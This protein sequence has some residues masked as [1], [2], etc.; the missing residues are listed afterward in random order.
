MRLCCW[1]LL[2]P[3]FL[4]HI[5]FFPLSQ[6]CFPPSYFLPC[7]SR[8]FI[9]D[10]FALCEAAS[11]ENV[12]L[13]HCGGSVCVCVCVCDPHQS[14]LTQWALCACT[15]FITPLLVTSLLSFY[16][17]AL[18]CSQCQSCPHSHANTHQTLLVSLGGHIAF[19]GIFHLWLNV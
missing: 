5:F 17:I 7:F 13:R 19:L 16:I 18:L 10:H 2:L 12:P 14:T 8:L 6:S 1:L 3:F 4:F 9:W 11:D 15:R